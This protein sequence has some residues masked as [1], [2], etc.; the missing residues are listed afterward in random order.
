MSRMI[1]TFDSPSQLETVLAWQ[2]G[3]REATL[4]ALSPQAD[5]AAERRGV[6]CQTIEDFYDEGELIAEGYASFP[7]IHWLCRSFDERLA[8][9]LRGTA[10]EG[11]VGY[12]FS[13]FQYFYHFKLLFDPVLCRGF[14]LDRMLR[15]LDP[16]RIAGFPSA[17]GP[18]GAE[19]PTYPGQSLAMNALAALAA[20]R[21]LE[22]VAL[23]DPEPSPLPAPPAPS[24]PSRWPEVLAQIQGIKAAGHALG[25]TI[26]LG[27][28]WS[29]RQLVHLLQGRGIPIL[30]LS[31][32]L[33]DADAPPLPLG[34]AM[35]RT[36]QDTQ[37]SEPYR[38]LTNVAGTSLS[39]LTDASWRFFVT[40]I[41]P[42]H[43]KLAQ[44]AAE[45][46]RLL[47]D[48]LLLSSFPIDV[49]T[50]AA[51][52]GAR[53]GGSTDVVVQ[54]G[55]FNGYMTYPMLNHGDGAHADRYLCYGPGVA[56]TMLA[57]QV[58][59]SQTG[60]PRP[61]RPVATGS[62]A[63]ATL[64]RQHRAAPLHRVPER[65]IRVLYVATSL[66][67]DTRYFSWHHAPEIDYA[68]Q[69]RA[70]IARCAATED[71]ELTIRPFAS[72]RR[73]PLARWL[74][75]RRPRVRIAWEVP[76]VQLLGDADVIL[77]DSPTTTLLQALATQA[78]VV[79]CAD[80]RW[81]KFRPGVRR[82]LERRAWIATRAE[83]VF[84]T[85]DAALQACREG[86]GRPLD[87]EFLFRYG[88]PAEG[89]A[90]ERMV[91]AILAARPPGWP[92]P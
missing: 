25:R 84:P 52:P 5:Y 26:I 17:L 1:A 47:E 19:F 61:V 85:L 53:A 74:E 46:F 34:D 24:V 45:R 16:G 56:E 81:Y 58:P 39:A 92:A 55:G 86:A 15:E 76:F 83:D 70:L 9:A 59:A 43:L 22:M 18:A 63:I 40:D 33:S 57:Q 68:R 69:Q 65:G 30:R 75:D 29:D 88:M 3:G 62:A 79:V 50:I 89:D 54:H 4:V 42:R 14:A 2:A 6:T 60:W 41:V 72:D 23:V 36:C 37:A 13:A 82:M 10:A 20:G 31:Q 90:A 49:E 77:V 7:R 11:A 78:Q 51:G 44:L 48:A 66:S 64:H 67:G 87:D 71:V 91:D 27:N 28:Y 38:L 35:E 32:I 8:Q 21:G 73:N 12:L 80:S